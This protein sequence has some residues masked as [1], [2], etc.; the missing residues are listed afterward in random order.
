MK[1][2]VLRAAPPDSSRR[3]VALSL[4]RLRLGRGEGNEVVLPGASVHPVHALFLLRDQGYEVVDLSGEGVRLNGRRVAR[5]AVQAGDVVHIA[6]H[7]IEIGA[8][9][10]ATSGAEPEATRAAAHVDPPAAPAILRVLARSGWRSIRL[11]RRPAFIGSSSDNDVVLD[12]PSVSRW[13]CRLLPGR[14]GFEVEDLVSTNG[15]F[16]N[17]VRVVRSA[18]PIGSELRLGRA[19]AHLLAAEIAAAEEPPT[20]AGLVGSSP[21]MLALYRSIARL[22]AERDPVLLL[23]ETGTGKELVA[24]ALQACGPRR[25][26]PFVALNCGAL[27]REIVESEM[28]GHERGAF[29]GAI[30]ERRG[31]FEEADGG[32]LF[33]DEVAE[34]GSEIQSKLL[35][36]LESGEVRRVGSNRP[37]RVDVRVIAACNRSLREM[38]QTG[39]FRL[40]LFHRLSVIELR[41][42]PLRERLEDLPALIQ[43]FLGNAGGS[44]KVVGAAAM[45]RLLEHA[46]PGNVRELRNVLRRASLGAEGAVIG[47]EHLDLDRETPV[48]P[49]APPTPLADIERRAIQ[50]ALHRNRGNKAAACRELGIARSTFFEK[51]RRYGIG[52]LGRRES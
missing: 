14:A 44:G 33:L 47:R 1:P 4:P 36:F 28:F 49:Q 18:V 23:G 46:W 7:Q 38:V 41:L 51:L 42:P 5:A 52:A 29:S 2:Q 15:T 34:L 45:A 30:R 50:I 21:L 6:H 25:D 10:S 20:F 48:G 26:R 37:R 8:T 11:P 16:V 24:R 27:P 9:A 13:H 17:G 40:D 32:T 39:R 19:V 22:A 35:R 3:V 31:L 43:H 12:D